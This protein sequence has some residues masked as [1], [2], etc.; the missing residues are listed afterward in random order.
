MK[1]FTLGLLSLSIM[2][3]GACLTGC[4]CNPNDPTDP[5]DPSVATAY[6][7]IDINPSIDL[8]VDQYGKVMSVN[9]N[10]DDARVLLYNETGIVGK[11]IEEAVKK[12]TTLAKNLG[13]LTNEDII[14]IVTQ[15][16]SQDKVN[17]IKS[18]INSVATNMGLVINANK[19]DFALQREF[20]EFKEK[21]P[22]NQTIQE[23]SI[24]KFKLLSSVCDTSNIN[25]EM[26]SE[27]SDTELVKRL[28]ENISK[29]EIYMTEAF[30]NSKNIANSVFEQSKIFIKDAAYIYWF[31]QQIQSNPQDG[32]LG[33]MYALYHSTG[34]S[35]KLL[36]NT[37]EGNLN[38]KNVT[39]TDAQIASILPSL[40]LDESDVLED[41][42]GN[43]TIASVENYLDEL[44]ASNQTGEWSTVKTSLD[45][46]LDSIENEIEHGILVSRD[47]YLGY[48]ETI[49]EK[50]KLSLDSLEAMCKLLEA[51]DDTKDVADEIKNRIEV[52]NNIIVMIETFMDDS[53]SIM[54]IDY[55]KTVA[56][57][58]LDI[59]D[60]LKDEIDEKLT[61]EQLSQIDLIQRTSLAQLGAAQVVF[62][63]A[64]KNA[65]EV[66]KQALAD[67][68]AS[69]TE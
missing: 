58:L 64:L 6:V 25:M 47:T 62:E 59:A 56:D 12:I 57:S 23:M 11:T 55:I 22:N 32:Y 52:Y 69:R 9:A 13:Y 43:V 49:F 50:T 46:V 37:V 24:S 39:L 31:N 66:A 3:S 34:E 8:V 20:E 61:T 27:L 2:A 4:K 63:Q 10:N 17:Q 21:Y 42:N 19:G 30:K 5:Q 68:K 51:N 65:E 33:A 15:G 36:A 45:M 16:I 29:I 53:E 40:N 28:N 41:I 38:I 18:S 1:K 14:E 7:N 54:N 48:L 60:E 44:M 26:A 35:L 67:I